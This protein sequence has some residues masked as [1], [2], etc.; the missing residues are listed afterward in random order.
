[1]MAK[2]MG[3]TAVAISLSRE[4]QRIEIEERVVDSRSVN[5]RSDPNRLLNGRNHLE[6]PDQAFGG[7]RD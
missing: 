7:C 4:Q 6:P 5:C 1:M 2:T 3:V